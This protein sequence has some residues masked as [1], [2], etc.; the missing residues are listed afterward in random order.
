[1]THA[2]RSGAAK[3]LRYMLMAAGAPDGF[4]TI[5]CAVLALVL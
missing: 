1:M 5:V 3:P 2:E 4:S